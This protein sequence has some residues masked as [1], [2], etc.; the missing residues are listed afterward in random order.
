M[1]RVFVE[2][3]WLH[4]ALNKFQ[5]TLACYKEWGEGGKKK[6]H[7]PHSLFTT[8]KKCSCPLQE[9]HSRVCLKYC[10]VYSHKEWAKIHLNSVTP[11][12]WACLDSWMLVWLICLNI[13]VWNHC[14]VVSIHFLT[15]LVC[16][17]FSKDTDWCQGYLFAIS[18]M[19]FC[20]AGK[21]VVFCKGSFKTSLQNT[22]T[23]L[24]RQ[25][26]TMTTVK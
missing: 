15:D 20:T 5:T 17:T 18:R 21:K 24:H 7:I 12:S 10:K 1:L 13:L 14:R 9:K 19:T 6:H 22:C 4:Q 16:F 11:R 23:V 8:A 26:F 25:D 2:Q 3:G